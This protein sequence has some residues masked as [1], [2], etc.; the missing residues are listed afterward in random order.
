[1]ANHRSLAHQY[2]DVT[3]TGEWAF[4]WGY[5]TASY[6]ESASGEEKRIRAK[7]L[8]VL[9]KQADGSWKCA[10]EMWNTSV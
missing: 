10:R 7:V 6:V 1:M 5:F 9:K 4:G 8:W 3:V 2:K